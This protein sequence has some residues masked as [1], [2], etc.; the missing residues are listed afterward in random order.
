[1]STHSFLR[2]TPFPSL[3]QSHPQSQQARCVTYGSE[4]QPSQRKR[5]RKHGFLSRLR[6]KKGRQLLAKRRMAG[7]RFLSH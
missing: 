4:Y 5:K 2:T 6:T 1:M 3:R 7:R